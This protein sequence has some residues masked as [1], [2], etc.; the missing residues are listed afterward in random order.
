MMCFVIFHNMIIEDKWDQNLKPLFDGTN[1]AHTW[2]DIWTS[3]HTWKAHKNYRICKLITIWEHIWWKIYGL[4]KAWTLN[5]LKLH[6]VR[7]GITTPAK[8][9]HLEWSWCITDTSPINSTHD[10]SVH[11]SLHVYRL[12]DRDSEKPKLTQLRAS[13]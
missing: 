7:C 1:V 2:K 8:K 4:E 10:I 6:Q 13:C 5:E 9:S 11:I 3:K 12:R